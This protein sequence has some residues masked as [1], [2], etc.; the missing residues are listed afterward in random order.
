MN[1]LLL[2]L[3]ALFH[4][5]L[6]LH[7]YHCIDSSEQLVQV[8]STISNKNEST[9]IELDS[10]VVYKLY[11]IR[12]FLQI[13]NVNSLLIQSDANTSAK[14]E[15][16]SSN[17]PSVGFAFYNITNL[18]LQR[19]I[20][21][22]C[23]LN[24]YA[25][26]QWVLQHINSSQFHFTT[27]HSAALVFTNIQSLQLQQVNVSGYY[28]FGIV[29]HNIPHSVYARIGIEKGSSTKNYFIGCGILLLYHTCTQAMHK[30][31][32]YIAVI[33]NSTFTNN[34]YDNMCTTHCEKYIYDMFLNGCNQ[35]FN[36]TGAA[37]LTIIY[38]N[39]TRAYTTVEYTTFS[40]NNGT[41]AGAISIQ[42]LD[43]PASH[44][45]IGKGMKFYY[46]S[47]AVLTM[48]SHGS[49]IS[50]FFNYSL[51]STSVNATWPLQ[52]INSSFNSQVN[53]TGSIYI[54]VNSY[55]KIDVFFLLQSL[56]FNN[57]LA[58]S[59]GFC[60]YAA[61]YGSGVNVSFTLEDI[62]AVNNSQIMLRSIL[63]QAAVFS[64]LNIN[65][66]TI[67]GFCN[68]SNNFGSVVALINSMA[69]LDGVLLFSNNRGY[70]GAAIKLLDN[71]FL[72]LNN[73]LRANF[74]NN[75]AL[76]SGG[77]I[78]A[79]S[80]GYLGHKCTF[81]VSSLHDFSSNNI[82]MYFIS[83]TA[84]RAG[85]SIYSNNIYRCIMNHRYKYI[86]TTTLESMY[87]DS[88][89]FKFIPDAGK[90]QAISTVPSHLMKCP[91]TCNIDNATLVGYPGRSVQL[92]I[93]ALDVTNK[94]VFS[95]VSIDIQYDENSQWHL[96][97][98]DKEQV[99]DIVNC[100]QRQR[101]PTDCNCTKIN[102]S[103][104][105]Y[106]NMPHLSIVGKLLFTYSFSHPIFSVPI[107]LRNCPVGFELD[108]EHH[109]CKCSP[110]VENFSKSI[111]YAHN[112]KCDIQSGTISRVSNEITW[113]GVIMIEREHKLVFAISR[114]CHKYC[115][116]YKGYDHFLIDDS[117]SKT[118]ITNNKFKGRKLL[119]P[120]NRE[121]PLCS[122][123]IKGTSVVFG[124]NDC[125]H[126]SDQWL[127]TIALYIALCPLLI[128]LMSTLKLTLTSGTLNGIIF[129]A[130]LTVLVK[131]DSYRYGQSNSMLFDV[132][133][134]IANWF[135]SV[136]NLQ[137][138]LGVPT[139]ICLYAEMDEFVK[140]CVQLLFPLYLL[141]I[142]VFLILASHYSVSLSNRI[143]PWSVQVLVTVIHLSFAGICETVVD[144]FMPTYIYV[145]GRNKPLH[146][147]YSDGTVEYG[148]GKHLC[149]MI[150]T[151]VVAAI[152]ILPYI[153]LLIGGRFLIR[154]RKF[155]KYLRPLHEAIHAP[156]KDKQQH[157]FGARLLLVILAYVVHACLRS[158][159]FATEYL[160]VLLLSICF[161]IAQAYY[162]PF[163][164]KI[165]NALD[166]FMMILITLSIEVSGFFALHDLWIP[167]VALGVAST[168]VVLCIFVAIVTHNVLCITGQL[169]KV[170][171]KLG[172]IAER[173]HNACCHGQRSG[174][175]RMHT[176][177]IEEPTHTM[178]YRE[179]L[180]SPTSSSV[181]INT[182]NTF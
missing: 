74:T 134:Y 50:H 58:S 105:S 78:Y 153:T 118:Y 102:I 115:N 142:V 14:I 97:K 69:T 177:S 143:S 174:R 164:N 70:S 28:G 145:E 2:L 60:L 10:T 76:T 92:P 130:Q 15:C 88:M 47:M 57:Y 152:L 158:Q 108:K 9:V 169:N 112:I 73:S 66:V 67:K 41:I 107:E 117:T 136:L 167:A 8:L 129:F 18:T 79:Y 179:P 55:R 13:S 119:C 144:V 156:Y 32:M 157:W 159:Y 91:S 131:D 171:L 68:F 5:S 7:Q 23:G 6:S 30:Q 104:M 89:I 22:Q 34:T 62:E 133:V 45:I 165:I 154:C 109:I 139:A 135:V 1:F 160:I 124:S 64:F 46:N 36:I 44:T 65:K 114:T 149:L 3:F 59:T 85:S 123:C 40:D 54:Y 81:Q 138:G 75:N 87:M 178:D 25:L 72:Q 180:L 4:F 17:Q 27:H 95:L 126:C 127:W 148:K 98:R 52:V 141:T 103:L 51:T 24:L 110:A 155:N 80:D 37:G 35:V 31:Y 94:S 163:K 125:K 38:S 99:I 181:S 33:K 120:T 12:K 170:K 111:D 106:K 147:W 84:V 128:Y 182:Y 132:S 121:G 49:D 113:A 176:L 173:V 96:S 63:A 11:N 90:H 137:L 21:K 150:G 39:N 140:T 56:N 101:F 100:S 172:A 82:S 43:S 16:N 77:A 116:L 166:L 162:R 19:L 93:V 71:S 53:S 161:T 146:V 48:H 151:S 122:R 86:N 61:S 26:D 168:M 83:N 175:Y 42:Q 29:S 20:F